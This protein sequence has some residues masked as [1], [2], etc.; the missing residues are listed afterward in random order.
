VE[1]C[2]IA[3]IVAHLTA[4]SLGLGS[5]W[6]QIRNRAHSI[7][8]TAEKHVQELLGIPSDLRVESIISIGFP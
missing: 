4:H 7:E 6:I 2:S 5:C 8:K 1:D 3:A